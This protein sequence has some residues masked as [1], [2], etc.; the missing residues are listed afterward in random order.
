[1]QCEDGNISTINQLLSKGANIQDRNDSG[2]TPFLL[3]CGHGHVSVVSLL[4]E[5]GANIR[6]VDG[7]GQSLLHLA[8]AGG[9]FAVLKY[10]LSLDIAWK[11]GGTQILSSAILFAYKSINLSV[12]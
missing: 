2:M 6:D 11:D 8:S 3:S 12:L 4:N 7:R 9:R 5:K 10:L 1:M